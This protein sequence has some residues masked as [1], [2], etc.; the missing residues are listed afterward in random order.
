M[1]QR[2]AS[3]ADHIFK[4]AKPAD[5][6]MERVSTLEWVINLKIAQALGITGPQSVRLRADEVIQ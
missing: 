4:S 2:V 6:P 1:A 5:L 3:Y